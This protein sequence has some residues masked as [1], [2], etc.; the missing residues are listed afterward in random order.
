MGQI[1]Q[2]VKLESKKRETVGSISRMINLSKEKSRC[3]LCKS[4]MDQESKSK[5]DQNFPINQSSGQIDDKI[6]QE[7]RQ[8][9]ETLRNL[10][11]HGC[12]NHSLEKALELLRVEK[13]RL[14]NKARD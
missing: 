3:F 11:E 14:Q 13:E 2:L 1:E 10:I 4:G 5:M 8:I 6:T 7:K 9:S 12:D